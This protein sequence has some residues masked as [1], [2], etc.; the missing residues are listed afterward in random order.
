VV[1]GAVRKR[2]SIWNIGGCYDAGIPVSGLKGL[3]LFL[4][5]DLHNGIEIQTENRYG[6]SRIGFERLDFVPLFRM[7]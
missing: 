7:E 2:Y 4:S 3:I 6:N 1:K 5:A